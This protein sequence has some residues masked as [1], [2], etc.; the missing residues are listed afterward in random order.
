MGR[1]QVVTFWEPR[2]CPGSLRDAHDEATSIM[3]REQNESVDEETVGIQRQSA[4]TIFI[5]SVARSPGR[6]MAYTWLSRRDHRTRLA[7]ISR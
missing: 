6:L 7:D 2:R 1:H 5:H 4:M 3:S